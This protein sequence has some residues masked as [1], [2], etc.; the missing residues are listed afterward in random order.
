MTYDRRNNTGSERIEAYIANKKHG[1]GF[2]TLENLRQIVGSRDQA[3]IFAAIKPLLDSGMVEP[4]KSARNNGSS[5]TPLFEKYRIVPKA[6]AKHELTELH[7]ILLSTGYLERNPSTCDKWWTE[8]SQ[9]SAWL[10]EGEHVRDKTLRERCWEVFGNEKAIE[11]KGLGQ[12]VYNSC[13]RDL[14]DLLL[15]FDDAPEDLPYVVRPGVRNPRTVLVSENRD[16]YLAVRRGLLSGK[17][18]LYGAPI[19]AVVYGRGNVVRQNGGASLRFTLESMGAETDVSV[20]YWGDIDREGLSILASLYAA[21]NV[22]PFTPAYEAMLDA[23]ALHAPRNSPDGR[24]LPIPNIDNLFEGELRSRI[25][26][27]VDEGRLLPQ[28]TISSRAVLE[29][30]M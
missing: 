7:P 30:M 18:T 26:K 16:P 1:K 14:R 28:E 13:N 10:S 20:L 5:L 25:L 19:D 12:C 21:A 17:T 27:V 22:L 6:V 8:L 9:L 23:A 3:S 2:I 15:A 29:A 11:V 4:L 24:D